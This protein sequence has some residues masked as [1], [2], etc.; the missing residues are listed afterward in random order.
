VVRYTNEQIYQGTL[1]LQ[2]LLPLARE[3]KKLAFEKHNQTSL[4]KAAI[5]YFSENNLQSVIISEAPLGGWIVDVLL[6]TTPPGVSN[7]LGTPTGYP[8]TSHEEAVRSGIDILSFIL[9]HERTKEETGPP[10]ILYYDSAF[11]LSREV[12]AILTAMGCE[13]YDSA[14]HAYQRL[15]EITIELFGNRMPSYERITAL[16][17]DDK[18]Q[19]Q[20]V[21]HMAVINGVLRYPPVEPGFPGDHFNPKDVD[22]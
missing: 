14:D 18:R 2:Q 1:L 20:S 10:A 21:L 13:G 5:P 6:K 7:I 12:L 15:K 16:S 17:D 19:L 8:L 3:A 9:S 4:M 11:T 22:I